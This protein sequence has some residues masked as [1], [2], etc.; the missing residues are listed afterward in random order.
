MKHDPQRSKS[1]LAE[2]KVHLKVDYS[3]SLTVKV[4]FVKKQTGDFIEPN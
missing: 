1:L 3:V 4:M 2:E